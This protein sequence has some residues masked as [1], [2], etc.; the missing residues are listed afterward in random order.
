MLAAAEE[1]RAGKGRP[2]ADVYLVG[3]SGEEIGAGSACF[4][5]ASLPGTV[6]LAVDVGPVAAE[7]GTRL[8]RDPIIGY[9]DK[10][11]VYTR[12]V[13]D[14]LAAVARGLGL[15]PQ[16][17]A[18]ENYGSDASIA[19]KTGNAPKAGLLGVPTENTHGFE[20]VPREALAECA[21]VLAGYLREPV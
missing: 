8:T 18:L 17:A 2:P 14:R 3:T 10:H 9:R 21:R 1:L 13:C 15:D 16:C 7:Y 19:R 4:A 6:S 11:T 5:S 12:S 20:I